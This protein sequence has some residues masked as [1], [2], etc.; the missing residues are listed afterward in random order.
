MVNDL[1]PL[2][3]QIARRYERRAR[4]W[5]TEDDLYSAAL[6]G[7]ALACKT[8]RADKGASFT[9]Y[10]RR[11]MLGEV[12]EEFR[13]RH[14][15][16][17]P[18]R[19]PG[20]QLPFGLMEDTVSVNGEPVVDYPPSILRRIAALT[21]AKAA[22]AAWLRWAE[23]LT[24]SEVATVLGLS[25]ARVWQLLKSVKAVCAVGLLAGCATRASE[26]WQIRCNSGCVEAVTESDRRAYA[27][28]LLDAGR[29]DAAESVARDL[30]AEDPSP[31]NAH[32]LGVVLFHTGDLTGALACLSE[33]GPCEY[34]GVTLYA[35]DR[36]MEAAGVFGQLLDDDPIT[37]YH[38]A[39]SLHAAG[40]DARWLFEDVL[41][42]LCAHDAIEP[43]A[44]RGLAEYE[45][46]QAS[47]IF[48]QAD[49]LR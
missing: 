21:S 46:E 38:V 41:S 1:L 19:K 22:R 3:R 37:E 42:R 27:A 7:L 25:T 29:I 48:A 30:Y 26:E 14:P 11:R 39:A 43:D 20:T 5:L 23:G 40:A 31:D 32:A 6:Y 12:K 13:S 17:R 44:L 34:L 2:A 9:T 35:L 10:A 36:D 28:D 24:C 8:W 15:V 16:F 47:R 18:R 45:P 49:Y 4:P 33:A